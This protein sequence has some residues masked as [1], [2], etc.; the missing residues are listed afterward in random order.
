MTDIPKAPYGSPCN[1]CGACC[2]AVLC[3]LGVHVFRRAEGPCPA[4]ERDEG[5]PSYHCGLVARPHHY[6]PSK[7]DADTLS[8]AAL[9]LIGANWRCDARIDGEPQPPDFVADMRRRGQK[10]RGRVTNAFITWGFLPL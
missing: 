1:G 3:P 8:R 6:R 7:A 10:L 5:K 2:N 4:L 9:I